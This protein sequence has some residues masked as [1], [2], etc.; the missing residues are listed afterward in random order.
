MKDTTYATFSITILMMLGTSSYAHQPDLLPLRNEEGM[1]VFAVGEDGSVRSSTDGSFQNLVAKESVTA[2]TLSAER[3][4]ISHLDV[5][6]IVINE[7]GSVS[8][9]LLKIGEDSASLSLGLETQTANFLENMGKIGERIDTVVSNAEEGRNAL[10]IELIEKMIEDKTEQ[11]QAEEGIREAAAAAAAIKEQELNAKLDDIRQSVVDA[12]E[13]VVAH[14][15]SIHGQVNA[16]LMQQ[17]EL[18]DTVIRI[19]TKLDFAD[20]LEKLL[21]AHAAGTSNE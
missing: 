14:V 16:K 10:K 5:G 6:N 7:V 12:K 18:L 1:V 11:L 17:Q 19:V 8:E 13:S 21:G 20:E 15:D 9:A 2:S 3:V 4:S